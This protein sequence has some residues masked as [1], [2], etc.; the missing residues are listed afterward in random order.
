MTVI[1]NRHN[2]K[3]PYVVLDKAT[4]W[5][6]KLSLKA[7]GLWARCISRPD[8]WK[9]CI[10]ELIKNCQEGR[11]SIYG[12]IKELIEVRLCLRVQH[13]I[14]NGRNG[15]TPGPVEY[16]F[17]EVPATEL[18]ALE[19]EEE[20]KSEFKKS[21][22]YPD[23]QEA[24]FE[25]LRA[26]ETE[27][28]GTEDPGKRTLPNK[29]IYNKKER[30]K[31]VP[32]PSEIVTPPPSSEKFHEDVISITKYFYGEL[33]KLYPDLSN[34]NIN[35]WMTE[36]DRMHRIDHRNWAQIRKAIDFALSDSFWR[37]NIL[38]PT[39]LRKNYD[40]LYAQWMNK[41]ESKENIAI[42]NQRW[43]KEFEEKMK[44]VAKFETY[45]TYAEFRA[46]GN[47]QP[48]TI[49][50]DESGFK[51]QVLNQTRKMGLI[52]LWEEE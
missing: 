15:N 13:R 32:T 37:A 23:F 9:F 8:N 12:G 19:I 39:S 44:Y 3:K 51:E 36:L 21:L 4:L 14:Q 27:D 38:S 47:A 22:S 31:N 1:R 11:D 45:T 50:Y 48:V 25:A 6:E 33:K 40:K 46:M 28:P 29:D 16:I 49:R 35:A 7:L 42:E 24:G 26:A 41:K 10:K 17:L 5:N 43:A 34:P 2:S 30:K 18:E 20:M 52:D